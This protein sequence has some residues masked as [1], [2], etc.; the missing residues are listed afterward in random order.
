LASRIADEYFNYV[1][2]RDHEFKAFQEL[3]ER[4]SLRY[5]YLAYNTHRENAA[6]QIC[7]DAA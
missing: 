1:G 6:V 2:W 3:V 4:R 5:R 7:E